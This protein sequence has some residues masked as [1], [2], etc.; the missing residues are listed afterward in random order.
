MTFTER[1]QQCVSK[2][3]LTA[4]DLARWFARP[5]ATVDTWL[6]GRTP[7]GPAGQ[8]AHDDLRLLEWSVKRHGAV[9]RR[10]KPKAR[11]ASLHERYQSASRDHPLPALRAAARGG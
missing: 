11:M 3:D 2:A 10:L 9:Y 4:A 5:R 8:Q 7:S 1:L 6:A